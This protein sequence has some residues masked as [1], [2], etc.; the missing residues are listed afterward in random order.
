MQNIPMKVD[1][2]ACRRNLQKLKIPKSLSMCISSYT[3][4]KVIDFSV[5]SRDVTGKPL[6]FFYSV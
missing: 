1:H 2:T 6:T 3:V 5:P 4:K